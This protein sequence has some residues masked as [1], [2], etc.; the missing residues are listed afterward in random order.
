MLVVWLRFLLKPFV[1]VPECVVLC[2]PML[3]IELLLSC[4]L[5][6][7]MLVSHGSMQSHDVASDWL[8]LSSGLGFI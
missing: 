6:W 7:G 5:I 4:L 1:L 8:A 2:E 3:C